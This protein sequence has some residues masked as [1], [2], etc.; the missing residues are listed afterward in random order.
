MSETMTAAV[1]TPVTAEPAI[2]A[3]N[4]S[5]KFGDVVA[6]DHCDLTVP[7][8]SVVTLLGPSGTGKSTM[9]RV[10]AGFD[11]PDSGTISIRG[12]QVVGPGVYVPAE[13]RRVGVVLQDYALFPHMTVLAN[14]SYGLGRGWEAEERAG[15][16]LEIVGLSGL[17]GRM[18]NEL[19]GG[20]QQRVALA[21]AMAPKPD[22]IILDEPFSNLDDTLRSRVR[23]DILAIIRSLRTTALFI[24]HDQEEALSISDLVAVMNR[25]RIVQIASPQELYWNPVDPWVGSFIG[26][27]NFVPG[28]SR[29][30]RMRS[31]IGEFHSDVDGDVTVMVRPE[32]VALFRDPA[33]Q[34]VVQGRE[35][36]GHDQLVTVAFGDG[37]ILKSRLGPE[38]VFSAGDRVSVQV[39]SVKCFPVLRGVGVKKP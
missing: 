18:P 22:V 34:A 2:E 10:L 39:D 21:R 6:L 37:T 5:K 1:E 8:G 12:R 13:Q 28:R 30:G 33:G 25:G 36:F 38:H 24:T 19:S 4:I 26:D 27:A 32:S 35:F 29:E 16:V 15:E 23:H 17:G 3:L 11:H 7:L 9:L 20:Q 31:I 14:V